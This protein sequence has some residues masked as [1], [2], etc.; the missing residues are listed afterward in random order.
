MQTADTY[1]KLRGTLRFLL[2]N[3]HDFNPEVDRVPYSELPSVDRYIL[4]R[5]SALLDESAAHYASFQFS[6]LVQGLLRFTVLDLSN[7]YLDAAKDRLYI[8]ARR[9]PGRRA[10]QTVLHELLQVCRVHVHVVLQNMP[11]CCP[12]RHANEVEYPKL[13]QRLM[14]VARG[15]CPSLRLSCLTW[16]K[17]RG[18]TCHTRPP[19]HPCSRRAGLRPRPS[20][21]R[22]PRAMLRSGKLS[23]PSAANLICCWSALEATKPWVLH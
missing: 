5:F 8:Q 10:C 16:R 20:G 14:L 7:F 17:M 13:I 21:I 4:S 11:A 9:S 3:L 19:R 15:C 18:K 6:R 2:G 22:F 12:S 23:L 1:R